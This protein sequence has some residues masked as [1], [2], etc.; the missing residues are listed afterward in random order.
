MSITPSF[1]EQY[2][3][4]VTDC[5]TALAKQ[6]AERCVGA[7]VLCAIWPEQFPELQQ[8]LASLGDV[9]L[10][11]AQA[12]LTL[13]PLLAIRNGWPYEA[14][15]F[16]RFAHSYIQVLARSAQRELLAYLSDPHHWFPSQAEAQ[17]R[18][19]LYTL[20]HWTL[21]LARY[22]PSCQ[23]PLPGQPV[24]IAWQELRR[25]VCDLEAADGLVEWRLCISC[26]AIWRALPV[27]LPG[28]AQPGQRHFL[29]VSVHAQ[30]VVVRV[31]SIVD[32][33]CDW[34]GRL[35]RCSPEERAEIQGLVERVGVRVAPAALPQEVRAAW[36]HYLEV[37]VHLVVDQWLQEMNRLIQEGGLGAPL[38]WS[39]A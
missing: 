2:H 24:P 8:R 20:E 22:Q 5:A 15:T 7:H 35:A 36:D 12:D 34:L 25:A 10:H 26:G 28:P 6:T 18:L 37:S 23:E 1:P 19:A 16:Q 11:A 30:P 4:R 17:A 13:V 32:V 31:W 38:C 14:S 29:D 3:L 39:P 9:L 27:A 33:F 21:T